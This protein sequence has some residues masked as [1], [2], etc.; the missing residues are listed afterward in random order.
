M[1]LFLELLLLVFLLIVFTVIYSF[2]FTSDQQLVNQILRPPLSHSALALRLLHLK[3]IGDYRYLYTNSASP[4]SVTVWYDPQ[5]PPPSQLKSLLNDIA[6][7]TL[8]R[9]LEIKIN[10]LP[11]PLP[12][13]LSDS[14]L[15]QLLKVYPPDSS[16]LQLF[17][18]GASSTAPTNA[19]LVLDAGSL[20]VFQETLS[21]LT[22]RQDL[23]AKLLQSTIMHEWGHL[24]GLDHLPDRNCIMSEMVEVYENRLFQ[25]SNIP[26]S[27]CGEELF[28]L[29]SLLRV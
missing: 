15:T 16:K 11:T 28:Q 3:R 14:D 19:G 6:Q 27:Y 4:L 5:F 23:Q 2:H 7:T 9:N 21:A 25:G 18:L 24:L 17:H 20:F 29:Q 13:Q 22:N 26:T 10:P 12:T 1:K 8:K